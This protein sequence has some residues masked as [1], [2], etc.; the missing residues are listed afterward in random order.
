MSGNFVVPPVNE[1]YTAQ[2][3]KSANQNLLN[4]ATDITF[5]L[6]QTWNN[7]GGYVTH[8]NGSTDFTVNQTGLYQLEFNTTIFGAPWSDTLKQISI[9]ITRS[10][11]PEQVTIIQNAAI[12]SSRNYGQSVSASF[13]LVTGDV[14]NCR[15]VNTYTSGT[16]FAQGFSN[17]F[18]L[19]TWFTW[20]FIQ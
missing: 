14:I 3:Y 1:V 2:Y 7:T 20:K 9:D 11:F 15:V 18:E 12:P 19:N 13:Y 17:P 10:P 4:G 16:P 5:D 6:T 8:T